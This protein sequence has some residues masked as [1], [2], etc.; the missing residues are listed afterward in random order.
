[1]QSA[2]KRTL[3]IVV[4]AL[5]IAAGVAGSVITH[6]TSARG[7]R[8]LAA[9]L[10]NNART[11]ARSALADKLKMIESQAMSAAQLPQIR[12][13]IAVFDPAT[14]IDGFR[15]EAWWAPFR[16]DFSVY[17]V[18]N[19]EKLLAVEGMAPA[20]LDATELIAQARAHRTASGLLVAGA[21][22]WPYAAGAAVIDVPGRAVPAVIFLAQAV[23]QA[24]AQDLAAK[25]GG[26]V[27]VSDGK[28]AM[29]SAGN[30]A[31]QA[32]LK[33]VLGHEG[34]PVFESADGTWAA[35]PTALVPGVT[36]WTYAGV[37]AQVDEY[38]RDESVGRAVVWASAIIVAGLALFLGLR[39]PP[40]AGSTGA[41]GEAPGSSG[42]TPE[43]GGTGKSGISGPGHLLVSSGPEDEDPE[44]A[45]AIQNAPPKPAPANVFGRYVLLDRLGEG[46]MAE[47]Y[48]AVT[49]G[50]EGF[51]RNFVVKR[52]RPEMARNNDVVSAFIDEANLAASLVHTN[53]VPVFDFGKMGD[54]YY[55][56]QEYILGR[57]LGRLTRRA[58]ETEAKPLP[59]NQVF[60]VAHETLKALDYA[61]TKTGQDGKPMNLVHRDVSPNNIL[62]SARG[63]VKLFDFGIAK[64]TNRITQTQ[65][66]MVKGNVRFMSPEQARGDAV[67]GRSDLFAVALVI[68][69][70]LSGDALY[71]ADTTYNL[72]V[73]AAQGL[74]EK[75]LSSLKSLPPQAQRVLERALQGSAADRFQSAAEFAQA[76][77][78][79]IA[80]A[81][82]ALARTMERLFAEDIKAEEARFASAAAA[83][84]APAEGD[85][86]ATAVHST[87]R[88]AQ[89]GK[90]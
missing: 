31:E 62:I 14:L 42:A 73:K 72:L 49:Y 33:S 88:F 47:V 12:G 60:Y 9:Q 84:A 5:A 87:K 66:G 24:F 39:R 85:S 17:G 29:L 34:Q 89:P 25:A 69:Y 26:A 83:G 7:L 43:R 45:T 53:I 79:F 44:G 36:L 75:E 58:L 22:K 67:D 2:Q 11:Q 48:T 46:G 3:A 65:F 40:L 23:D 28:S 18:A 16:N 86:G 57:D 21:K 15:S 35:M 10:S 32:N 1:M 37:G 64:A 13:Q 81:H 82:D 51:R 61:H 59:L 50:A 68:Y 55:M 90:A 19:E 76:L 8:K 70:A 41:T 27:L 4:A 71:T 20:E 80:G 56:A 6:R 77:A 30:E 63:E 38:R 78:P 52:L 74:G 54:E